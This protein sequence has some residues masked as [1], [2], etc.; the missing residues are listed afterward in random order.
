VKKKWY[1]ISYDHS[2]AKSQ[3]SFLIIQNIPTR[4]GKK[5]DLNTTYKGEY[6]A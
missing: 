4:R 1:S 5:V 6:I 3:T 2:Y